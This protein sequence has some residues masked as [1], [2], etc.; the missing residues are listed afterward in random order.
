MD[1]RGAESATTCAGTLAEVT[2]AP[3]TLTIVG[4]VESPLTDPARVPTQGGEG[5]PEPGSS[6]T[7]QCAT[8]LPTCARVRK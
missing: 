6:S 7:R 2:M 8:C 4:H 1:P 5:A 3:L